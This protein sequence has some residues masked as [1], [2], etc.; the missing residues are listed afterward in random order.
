MSF[1]T[2]SSPLSQTFF[3][4]LYLLLGCFSVFILIFIKIKILA[5]R[6]RFF[7]PKPINE[8]PSQQKDLSLTT[9]TKNTYRFLSST[10]IFA[11]LVLLIPSLI[12]VGTLADPAPNYRPLILIMLVCGSVSLY[13]Y[14]LGRAA[15]QR[16][17]FE[18]DHVYFG[19]TR[20]DAFCETDYRYMYYLTTP[21]KKPHRFFSY[22]DKPTLIVFR[23]NIRLPLFFYYLVDRFF[24]ASNE[25][26]QVLF[27]STWILEKG[28]GE[29]TIQNNNNQYTFWTGQ[30]GLLKVLIKNANRH[31]LK[32]YSG[33]SNWMVI[34]LTLFP[35]LAIAIALYI[36]KIQLGW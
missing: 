26:R 25:N 30:Q 10:P 24:P 16:I 35:L 27:M 18:E 32:V 6:D 9:D 21:V 11:L 33:Q 28:P 12:L 31:Q 23:K 3:F 2:N 4:T 19:M 20:A 22:V 34:I 13:L 14:Y 1:N 29:Q 7:P 15:T 5:I 36:R 17:F 8:T